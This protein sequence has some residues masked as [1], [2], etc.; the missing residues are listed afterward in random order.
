VK[1]FSTLI[2]VGILSVLPGVRLLWAE[3]LNLTL[4]DNISSSGGSGGI[5]A[6]PLSDACTFACD[7]QGDTAGGKGVLQNNKN[8]SIDA[9]SERL[10]A[11]EQQVRTATPQGLRSL[12]S[13]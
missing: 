1:R 6:Q 9:L 5:L 13:K 8:A 10:A 2:L 4:S 11:L 12:A 7:T 3:P